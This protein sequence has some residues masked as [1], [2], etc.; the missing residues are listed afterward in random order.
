MIIISG[1]STVGKNPFIVEAC[2]LFP[3]TFFVPITT[4]TKRKDEIDGRDY[5]FISKEAFQAKIASKEIEQWDYCL[6][7]YY[8]YNGFPLTGKTITH[9]LSRMAIRIKNLYPEKITTIFLMPASQAKIMTTLEQ[10][11]S[12]TDLVLRKE[13]V[14]EEICHSTLFDYIFY[15]ENHST[16]LLHNEKVF[17]VLLEE[18]R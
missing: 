11:Y 15:V 1:P 16:E 8:G 7:N 14:Q 4:R 5:L 6:K 13:L 18:V 12:G 9:G 10:I 2:N 3:L 17:R